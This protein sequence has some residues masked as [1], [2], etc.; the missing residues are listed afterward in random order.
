MQ[1]VARDNRVERIKIFDTN[2]PNCNIVVG[3]KFKDSFI[4]APIILNESPIGVITDNN[5]LEIIDNEWF[6]DVLLF[7]EKNIEF[8]NY[9]ISGEWYHNNSYFLAEFL[10]SVIAK[11]VK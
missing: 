6:A 3:E 10:T 5:N 8:E 1:K 4:N 2:N 11:E 9:E 7:T